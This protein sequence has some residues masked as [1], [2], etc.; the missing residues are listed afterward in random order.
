A[1]AN[2]YKIDTDRILVGGVS[3]GA[4]T[5]LHYAYLDDLAELPPGIDTTQAGLGGGLAGLSGN[6]GYPDDIA[7]VINIAGALDEDEWLNAGDEPVVSLHGTADATIPYGTGQLTFLGIFPLME[8]D[9]SETIHNRAD[10]EGVDNCLFAHP[11]ADHVPHVGDQAYTDTTVNIIKNFAYHLVCGGSSSCGLLLN[12]EEGPKPGF[13]PKA[14]PNPAVDHF[15]VEMPEGWADA[16][17]VELVDMQGKVVRQA[18]FEN[19]Q[20]ADLA[21]EG[22]PAGIYLISVESTDFRWSGKIVFE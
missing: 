10:A 2:T 20:N 21:R 19:G 3:A 22:L 4:V 15:R 17:T 9:G 12:L 16:W 8:V 5:A 1:N 7:G 6:P 18:T 14:Y 13:A 11:G